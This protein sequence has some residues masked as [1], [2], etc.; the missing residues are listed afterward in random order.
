MVDLSHVKLH[1]FDFGNVP[2]DC[3]RGENIK[4]LL[5]DAGISHEYILHKWQ[6]WPKVRDEWIASGYT[7][8]SL[9]VI[10]TADGKRY[11]CTTPIAR[12]LSRQLGK[13][14]GKNI[15]DEHLVD[16]VA[17]LAQD[18]YYRFAFD[19]W[20]RPDNRE[21]HLQEDVPF[22]LQRLERYYELRDGPYV[23]GSE[24]SFADFQTYHMITD[25]KLKPKDLPPRLAAL[26]RTIEE[27]PNIAKYMKKWS[28]SQ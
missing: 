1:Y 4:L 7:A 27:R 5:E 8:G 28:K 13:Y 12:L 9:P 17:D 15:D 20:L 22:H 24:I 16:S 25:E 2:T 26:V 10:E 19:S 21:K 3:G 6:D 23:L 14:Y 11:S 18:W